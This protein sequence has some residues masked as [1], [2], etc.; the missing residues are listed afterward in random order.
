VLVFSLYILALASPL[1]LFYVITL[2][3]AGPGTWRREARD[4]RRQHVNSE[5]AAM[6]AQFLVAPRKALR[7]VRDRVGAR[8]AGDLVQTSAADLR[9][10]FES[11][12]RSFERDAL[13]HGR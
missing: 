10:L 2:V 3:T 7:E 11:A 12:L 13:Q 9:N 6:E 5:I 8:D 1:V 4:A